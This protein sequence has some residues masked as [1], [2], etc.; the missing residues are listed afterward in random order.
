M[1]EA[2]E[3]FP[4]SAGHFGPP[5]R[6]AANRYMHLFPDDCSADDVSLTDRQEP[7]AQAGREGGP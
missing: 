4:L 2:P 5:H 7:A 6:Y 3:T 1:I